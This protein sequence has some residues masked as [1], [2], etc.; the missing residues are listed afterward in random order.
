MGTFVTA[1]RPGDPTPGDEQTRPSTLI[2]IDARN[3]IIAR[4][5]DDHVGLVRAESE[6]PARRRA[7]GHVR[8][9]PSVRH[10]GGGGSPQNAGEPQRQEHLKR[11]LTDVEH[12]VAPGDDLLILGSGTVHER[13][14]RQI[15]KS[16]AHHGRHRRI[17]CEAAAPLTERQLIARLRGFAGLET[18]RRTIGAYRWSEGAGPQRPRKTKVMSEF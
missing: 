4:W 11:F 6:V 14:R 13:L 17:T 2:W 15:S 5:Q 18:R 16:D 1:A 3:A 8:H 12:R 10:G 9:D 7:T